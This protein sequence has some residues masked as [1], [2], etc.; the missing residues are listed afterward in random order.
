MFFLFLALVS[1]DTSK[2]I[3]ITV[4]PGESL[5]VT[6]V[7][8]GAPVVLLPGL[9]GSS[10]GYRHVME[11]LDSAGYRAVGVEP[12]GMGTSARPEDAD[13]SLAAQAD[14]LAAVLD[15]L[16]IRQAVFVGHSLGSSIALRVAY[17]NPELVRGIVSLE[18]GAAESAATAGFRRWMRFAPLL[19]LFD[20]RQMLRRTIYNAMK[21]VSFDDSWVSGAIVAAYTAGPAK[22]YQGTLKAYQGMARAEE[23]ELL[24]DHLRE[25]SCSVVLL[26]G[27]VEHQSGPS[28]DE[29]TLLAERLPS[30]TVDTV[31]RSGYFIQEEQP[32][33]VVSAVSGIGGR[34]CSS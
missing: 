29:L 20:G 23:P 1:T 4:A 32:A 3:H 6:I 25:I 22:D 26:V 7:G 21:R 10:Y 17:R 16:A 27:Q 12:L 31:A 18:G 14:R 34:G 9:F 8:R 33:A 15:T 24:R 19:R 2:T 28:A 30:F 13:Y 5:A 11:L